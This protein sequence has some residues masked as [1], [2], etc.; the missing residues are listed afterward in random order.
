M[1]LFLYFIVL[2][3][4]L[5]DIFVRTSLIPLRPPLSPLVKLASSWVILLFSSLSAIVD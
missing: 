2:S 4:I 3:G 5:P 1:L